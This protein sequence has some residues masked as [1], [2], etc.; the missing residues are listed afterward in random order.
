LDADLCIVGAGIIPATNFFKNVKLERDASVVCDQTLKAVD[1]DGLWT[2][3]DICRYPYWLGAPNETVRVEHWGMAQ[4]HGKIA[5]QNMLGKNIKV[6]S[7]PYFWTT[8][9]GK[10]INYCGFAYQF[11]EFFV[12]GNMDELK[13]VGYYIKD[14]KVLAVVAMGSDPVVSAAAELMQARKMPTGS[15][16]KSNSIDLVKFAANAI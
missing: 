8:Q 5:A 12:T 10:R 11:D 1:T 15:Q 4:F 14:D 9:F 16:I 13:F 3:G 2:G 6:E 7:V